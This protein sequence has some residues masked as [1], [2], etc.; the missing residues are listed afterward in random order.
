M[1]Y[2][3]PDHRFQM[4]GYLEGEAARLKDRRSKRGLAALPTAALILVLPFVLVYKLGKLIS[5]PF[6]RGHS[7]ESQG[8]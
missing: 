2:I 8:S 7:A 6:R 5:R 1:S 3:P 4:S